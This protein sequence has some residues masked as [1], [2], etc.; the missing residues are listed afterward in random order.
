MKKLFY[1]TLLGI[2]LNYTLAQSVPTIIEG[3][4]IHT[5][6]GKVIED[7]YLGFAEG[8]I[9]LCAAKMDGMYKNA[10]IIGAKGKHI[11]P[12]IICMGSM[13]GLNEI[14]AVRATLDFKETGDINPNVRSLIAYNTD[15][16]ILPT[17][18]S[19]GILFT[20]SVPQGGLVSGTSSLM[21]THAWNWEDA[22]IKTDDGV[23]VNWPQ[24]YSYKGWWAEPGN[25]QKEKIENEL[26]DLKQFLQQSLQYSQQ[27]KPEVFNARLDAMKEVMKGTKNI[28]IHANDAKTIIAAIT[29]C[30]QFPLVKIILI[31]A[32]DAWQ[33]N[34]L[35]VKHKIPVVFTNVHQLPKHNHSNLHQP[36]KTVAELVKSGITVAIGHQGY[37]ETR[38]LVFNA[39]TAAAYGLSKEQALQCIT[40]NPAKIMGIDNRIGSL[41]K[42]KDASFI[43]STGDILDMRTSIVETIFLDGKGVDMNN[44]QKQLY[45]KYLDKYNLKN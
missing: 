8:K 42:G 39:G 20:Q 25:S 35:L 4:T 36:Y 37:W 30:T 26:N 11:Y 33:V 15:S 3:A 34:A 40:A 44:H 24:E 43:I 18:L 1:T 12:G 13:L 6:T 23:H 32:A 38:N 45:Q 22:A 2:V 10:I 41:E 31:D 29:Y 21:R 7:G 27:A 17:A 5:A 9:F 16:K 14:E 19:N 28:Y